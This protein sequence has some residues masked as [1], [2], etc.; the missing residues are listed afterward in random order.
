[1]AALLA[2]Q[3][4]TDADVVT[5]PVA[6]R[7]EVEPE[8]WIERGGFFA[9]ARRP[10]GTPMDRAFTNNVLIRMELLRS[11]GLRF[12]ERFS[13]IGGDDVHFFRRAHAAGARI[14]WADDALVEDD[15]PSERLASSRA[16]GRRVG[17]GRSFGLPL[18]GL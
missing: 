12:D 17:R 5:G 1:M 16:F 2:V 11:T 7:Y 15:V 13:L 3:R 9:R 4:E 18:L 10:T 8:P 14:V 6:P